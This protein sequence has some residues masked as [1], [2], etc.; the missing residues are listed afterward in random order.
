M[1]SPFLDLVHQGKNQ[2][3]RYILAL[4]LILFM[5]LIVGSVPYIL[6][7]A[8][9]TLD[10]DPAT[11]FDALTGEFTG[12]DPVIPFLG[13]MLSFPILLGGV[14]LA[15]RFIHQRPFHTLLSPRPL[16]WSRTAQAFGLWFLLAAVIAVFEAIVYPYVYHL[17]FNPLQFAVFILFAIVLIPLQTSTEEIFFRGYLLQ[18]ASVWIKNPIALSL[19]SGV[20][21]MLPHLANPEVM[22]DFILLPIFYT[23]LGAF[24][25]FISIKDNSLDLALGV[26][27]ANNLF[28]AIFANYSG[29]A[30]ATPAIFTATEF[31][32]AFN[33]IGAILAMVVFYFWFFWPGQPKPA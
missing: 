29:S 11:N 25:A 1:P 7:V 4:F 17:T 33:V 20:V 16:N 12:V 27:A 18:G 6:A 30:L 14:Y 10:G 3:W 24:L 22:S 23:A 28:T 32:V 21:F 13:L 26:H 9:V 19:I 8:F 31:N 15:V 5:W 2:P